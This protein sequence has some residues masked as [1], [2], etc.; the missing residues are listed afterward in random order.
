[1]KKAGVMVVLEG[2]DG[3]GTTTQT[4]LLKDWFNGDGAVYGR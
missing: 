2:L 1:M 3:S 4:S